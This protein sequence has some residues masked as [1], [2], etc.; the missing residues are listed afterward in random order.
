MCDVLPP[1]DW[2]AG[3]C[4][5]RAK[6]FHIIISAPQSRKPKEKWFAETTAT[7]ITRLLCTRNFVRGRDRDSRDREIDFDHFIIIGSPADRCVVV[8]AVVFVIL[9]ASFVGINVRSKILRNSAE[10]RSNES[11][12]GGN[13]DNTYQRRWK[14]RAKCPNQMQEK[15]IHE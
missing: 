4:M 5:T 11:Q 10:R 15:Q 8:A 13:D 7:G 3:Q 14:C 2:G 6:Q 1:E 12:H 9:S